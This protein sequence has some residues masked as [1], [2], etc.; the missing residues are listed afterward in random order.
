MKSTI[1][2][3]DRLLIKTFL[4]ANIGYLMTYAAVLLF[5]YPGALIGAHLSVVGADMSMYTNAVDR[6][7][8]NEYFG[9]RTAVFFGAPIIAGML[10]FR[11][12]QSKP[13]AEYMEALPVQRNEVF[14]SALVSGT[15]LVMVPVLLC[16]IVMVLLHS[17]AGYTGYTLMDIL[18]W[19]CAISART[20]LIYS[21][22]VLAGTIAG[23][24]ILQG[25]LAVFLIFLPVVLDLL[26]RV[27]LN[28][29]I[30]SYAYMKGMSYRNNSAEL[31]DIRHG[32]ST[33]GMH[34]I[35]FYAIAIL[36]LVLV[37]YLLFRKRQ[38][39]N[40]GQAIVFPKIRPVLVFAA[41][42]CSALFFGIYIKEMTRRADFLYV[43]YGMGAL[44]A[45]VV[46]EM[47][48]AKSFRFRFNPK[49][50]GACS[51]VL[52]LA[53]TAVRMDLTGFQKRTSDAS[54]IQEVYMGYDTAEWY[55]GKQESVFR[56]REIIKKIMALHKALIQ[57]GE[58][59]SDDTRYLEFGFKTVK[60]AVYARRYHVP[61]AEYQ[62][63]IEPIYNSPEGIASRIPII[64]VRPNRIESVT[65]RGRFSNSG[66]EITDSRVISGL[67]EA[68]RKDAVK[69]RWTPKWE[70]RTGKMNLSFMMKDPSSNSEPSNS[71]RDMEYRV[72]NSGSEV[73]KYLVEQGLNRF[74]NPD[75]GFVSEIYVNRVGDNNAVAG[76]GFEIT[77]PKEITACLNADLL[78]EADGP[79]SYQLHFL[80]WDGHEVG[81][82]YY[83]SG[84]VPSFISA[85]KLA[86]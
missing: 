57:K 6:L 58:S 51:L 75:V 22:C 30:P 18:N 48:L 68:V 53:V 9:I 38:T 16:S 43:G 77:E 47:V 21:A 46:A 72:M 28:T 69:D 62:Q 52:I 83:I 5:L 49:L 66:T 33:K 61:A 8:F 73:E 84:D 41:V 19:T 50:F 23:T 10:M 11:F 74:L 15:I 14:R 54:E 44:C 20:L 2:S 36:V 1:L 42:F 12:S 13:Q 56:D 26:I 32:F 78:N 31:N 29:L 67:L 35:G 25:M 60:G 64:S 45:Y 34:D 70:I 4:K 63:Y 85:K 76:N 82:G 40:A 59:T 80:Q 79:D 86:E 7:L 37:A 27:N 39:E 55:S 81:S 71:V 65:L 17:V 3:F 24:T